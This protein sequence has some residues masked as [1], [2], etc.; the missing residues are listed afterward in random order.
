MRIGLRV[1]GNMLTRVLRIFGPTILTVALAIVGAPAYAASAQSVADIV[2]SAR[3]YKPGT[4]RSHFHLWRITGDGS[5]RVPVTAG[6]TDD[7]EPIWMV[8]GK[9][10][11]FVRE[12]AK[13][14]T[15]CTVG[16]RGGPVIKVAALHGEDASVGSVAPDRRRVVYFVYDR[17]IKLLLFDL[18]TRQVHPLGPPADMAWS[19]DSRH[20]YLSKRERGKLPAEIL[21]LWTGSRRVLPGNFGA[22]AWLSPHTLIAE[23]VGSALEPVQPRLII[24]RADGGTEREI[25]LA[26][27]WQDDLSP[28]ADSLFAI[29]DAPDVILYARHAGDSSAGPAQLFYRVNLKDGS[30][31]VL[32]K[33]RGLAWSPDHQSFVT[34]DGRDLAP[35]DFKRYVW[36]SSMSLVSL[37]TGQAHPLVRGMVDVGGFDWRSP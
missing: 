25:S 31:A 8:D 4:Q 6:P 32:T 29:P 15:L 26:F 24:L 37:T 5:R 14:S 27:N 9:S 33:G 21:D 10:V 23:A 22:A 34:G 11:L 18:A 17:E 2:F 12:V 3:Y 16:I 20:L 13:R 28:F 19:P 36:V 35:L 1:M 7:R 30:L